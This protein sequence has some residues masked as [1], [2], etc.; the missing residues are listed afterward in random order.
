[1]ALAWYS[2]AAEQGDADAQNNL[3][4]M[5]DAGEGIRENNAEAL[6]WYGLSADQGNPIAQNNLGAMYY[7]GEGAELDRVEAY[8]WFYIAEKLGSDDGKE[9]RIKSARSMR[10][11]EVAKAKRLAQEWLS[12]FEE[13]E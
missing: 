8:K 9:N 7:A 6:R 4:A 1:V 2:R 12:D 5:Y 3:G 11:A 10:S 13:K